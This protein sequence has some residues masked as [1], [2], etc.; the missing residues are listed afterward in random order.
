M[1]ISNSDL[2]KQKFTEDIL[3]ANLDHLNTKTILNTQILSAKFC[4]DHILCMENIDDGDE[5]SYLFDIPHILNKQ[6]HIKKEDL[7][8]LYK[9]N[10]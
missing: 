2:H 10:K 3:L 7:L 5:D 1:K 9:N 6:R 4:V 8:S